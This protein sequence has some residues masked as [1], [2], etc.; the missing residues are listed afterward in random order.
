MDW[1]RHLT[2]ESTVAGKCALFSSL[3]TLD[4]SCKFKLEP[5]FTVLQQFILLWNQLCSINLSLLLPVWGILSIPL[6][7]ARMEIQGA[8]SACFS[9]CLP[10]KASLATD[11]TCRRCNSHP[12]TISH[13]I[14]WCP[15][16][17]DV[18]YR[19]F[20]KSEILNVL[21]ITATFSTS[22]TG[23]DG[24]NLTPPNDRQRWSS[25]VMLTS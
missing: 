16:S 7:R 24:Y 14:V 15:F 13:L 8:Q 4:V 22:S 9:V 6:Q 10:P 21:L 17:V 23:R 25:T 5:F 11:P 2:Y 20:C 18:W 19:T 1:S 3:W 12:E